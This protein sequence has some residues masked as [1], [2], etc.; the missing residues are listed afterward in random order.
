M[1]LGFSRF[2]DWLQYELWK[3]C[4]KFFSVFLFISTFIHSSFGFRVFWTFEL[5]CT[6]K[7]LQFYFCFLVLQGNDEFFRRSRKTLS[8]SCVPLQ[9][10]SLIR[11]KTKCAANLLERQSSLEKCQDFE[12]RDNEMKKKLKKKNMAHFTTLTSTFLFSFH[13]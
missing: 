3:K 8:I 7:N 10:F 6:I 12:K 11:R 5:E 13:S 9:N 2:Y 1:L 4:I